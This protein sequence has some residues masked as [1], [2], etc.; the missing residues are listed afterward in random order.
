MREELLHFAY[1][2]KLYENAIFFNTEHAEIINIGTQNFDSGPDFI[3]AKLKTQEAVWAGN[4]EI[5]TKSSDWN[6]HKHH[7]DKAYNN[8]ILHVVNKHDCDVYT[9]NGRLLPVLQID[10]A[11]QIETIYDNFMAN[12][13]GISCK[14]YVNLVDDFKLNMWLSQVLVQRL[15]A[16][17]DDIKRLLSFNVN[18]WELVLYQSLAKGFGLKINAE[19]FEKLAKSVPL[20]IIAKHRNAF[21]IEALFMG[22]AGF[23]TDDLIEDEYFLE[24][25]KE[26]NFLR[27]KFD[28]C[29]MEKHEW[30]FLRLR[31][32]NFPT[33]RISQFANLMSKYESLFSKILDAEN[34][35][36]L[37]KIFNIKASEYWN[38]HYIFGKKA[39]NRVKIMGSRSV[40]LIMINALIPCL[41]A[42]GQYSDNEDIKEKAMGFLEDIKPEKNKIIS[43]WN[44][45]GINA[46]SSFYTQAL[47]EQKKS[48]CDKIRCLKCGIGVEILKQNTE[49]S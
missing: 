25:Q 40:D 1:K 34:I 7:T 3:G 22:Q 9:E 30:K 24:L 29:P 8:V 47:L 15:S 19:P 4:I 49:V 14:D 41:F 6:L 45:L 13:N 20:T 38:T 48:Y 35:K 37:H 31:P 23:L 28:L 18:N 17:V 10:V 27:N 11:S 21:Q 36:D 42:Y 16:K 39:K 33:I 44:S 26:Y 32:Y 43:E 12:D 5:H 2:Y 46:K